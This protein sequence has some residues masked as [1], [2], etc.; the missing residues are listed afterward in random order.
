MADRWLSSWDVPSHAFQ[1]STGNF[2]VAIGGASDAIQLT[3]K[4]T[5]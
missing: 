2:G 1:L 4:L 5:V 3:G